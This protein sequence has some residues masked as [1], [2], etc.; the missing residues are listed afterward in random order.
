MCKYYVYEGLGLVGKQQLMEVDERGLGILNQGEMDCLYV[1]FLKII[2]Y[3]FGF[4]LQFFKQ[5]EF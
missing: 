3:N 1:Y 2:F 5:K 4:E